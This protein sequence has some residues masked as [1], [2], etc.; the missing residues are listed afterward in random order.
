MRP[1]QDYKKRF[2]LIF[3]ILVVF[4]TAPV[5]FSFAQTAKEL[6][7]KI[8]QRKNDIAKLEI[9]IRSYQKEL[10]ELGQEKNSLSS[11]IKALDITRK[12]LNADISITENK[13]EKTNIR[14]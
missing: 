7:N 9:E 13:I 6:Q 2:K 12:K 10:D 11:S 1:F 14:I 4:L 8:D 5:F 3:C